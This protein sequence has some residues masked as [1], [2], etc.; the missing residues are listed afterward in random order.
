VELY[1]GGGG[2]HYKKT[3]NTVTTKSIWEKNLIKD[4]LTSHWK[5]EAET[6]V[7]EGIMLQSHSCKKNPAQ[8]ILET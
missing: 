5:M 3:N 6:R 8:L 2:T 7:I 1:D 4:S